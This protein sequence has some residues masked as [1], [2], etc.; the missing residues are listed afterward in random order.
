MTTGGQTRTQSIAEL[1]QDGGAQHVQ[2]DAADVESS[3]VECLEIEGIAV[4]GA[5][6]VAKLQP[7]PLADLVGRR[8][9]RPTQIAVQ[10]EPQA[11]L[12][13]HRMNRQQL[14]GLLVGP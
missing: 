2:A 1:L 8:L 14:P 3:A 7:P 12:V 5:N 11:R 6:V 13:L 10:L 4:S 9:P